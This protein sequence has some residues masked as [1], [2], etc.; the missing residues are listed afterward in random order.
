MKNTNTMTVRN[1][2][3]AVISNEVT[4]EVQQKAIDMLANMDAQTE[5]RK[6]KRAEQKA[7]K[8][9]ELSEVHSAILAL[10][11]ENGTMF[12]SDIAAALDVKVQT[13]TA[14]LTALVTHGYLTSEAIKIKGKGYRTQYTIAAQ[15]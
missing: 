9:F 8:P 2:L 1:F 15:A 5:A 6:A 11:Q 3:N 13:I 12:G 10:V 7:T 14:K 4:P